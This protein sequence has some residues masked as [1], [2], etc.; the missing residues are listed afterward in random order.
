M[1]RA[2]EPLF[3]RVTAEDWQES[4]EREKW[5]DMQQKTSASVH[6]AHALPGKLPGDKY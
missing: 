2:F 5:D 1:F 3:L 4:R 6:G